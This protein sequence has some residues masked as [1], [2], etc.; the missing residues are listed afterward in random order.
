MQT[1]KYIIVFICNVEVVY[2]DDIKRVACL[3][4]VSTKAQ[5]DKLTDDIPMQKIACADF[6]NTQKKWKLE[7]EYIEK[8]VSGY[9]KTAVERDVLQ[10]I[11][12]DALEKK[13]DVLLVFMFDRLGRREDETPFVV[14]WF[15]EQ[16]VE[17][18]S[19]KEGQQRFDNR[20]DKLI[21]YIRFWQSGGESEKTGIRV[22]EKHLQMIK[23]G[24]FCGGIAPFGYKLIKSGVENKKGRE[25]KKMI[26][27]E[28]EADIVKL[29][30]TLANTNG[31]GGHRISRYL[32]DEN[33]PTRKNSKWGLTVCNYMLRNPIYKGYPAYGKTSAVTGSNRRNNPSDW[34]ISEVKIDE[35]AIVDEAVWEKA[36]LIRNSR[37]PNCYKPE[38]IKHTNYPIQTKSELL[39]TG[40]IEC[41]YCGSTMCSYTS[42]AKWKLKDG[43]E[44]REVKPSYRCT[45]VNRGIRC[46]QV[47]YVAP[48]IEEPVLDEIF[49]YLDSLEK[50]NLSNEI[51]KVREKTLKHKEKGIRSNENKLQSIDKQIAKLNKEILKS[52]DGK[53]PFT[54]EQ[55]SL[56][57]S[58]HTKEKSEIEKQLTQL[59]ETIGVKIQE[60]DKFVKLQSMIPNWRNEFD[61]SGH[62]VKKMMISELIQ[63]VIVYQDLIEVNFKISFNEFSKA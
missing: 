55:L 29:V 57:L 59:Q 6:I 10:Q 1:R 41:G 24:K 35:L 49:S 16:D 19:V 13:F 53:S 33:I 11:K 30:Y 46:K 4:R 42:I 47:T 58:Q 52:L 8:G 37:T 34:H 36:Q 12:N 28:Q 27:D 60:V 14:E 62:D 40:F 17:V 32:N 15:V 44:K 25:V 21:N 18:W 22:K 7:K 50:I 26:I 54:P 43:T 39:F 3:Y 51:G 20:A 38:N 5:M 2:M 63:E 23:D 45:S 56:A 48:R 9:K 61:S 31:W